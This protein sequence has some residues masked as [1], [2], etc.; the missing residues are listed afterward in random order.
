MPKNRRNPKDG[1]EPMK[2]RKPLGMMFLLFAFAGMA[3]A[4]DNSGRP[5]KIEALGR[6]AHFDGRSSMSLAKNDMILADASEA[7][8]M[9]WEKTDGLGEKDKNQHMIAVSIGGGKAAWAS[10]ASF[11][12]DPTGKILAWGRTRDDHDPAQEIRTLKPVVKNG[13]WHHIAAVFRYDANS[14]RLFLDG[15]PIPATK[16]APP[17]HQPRTANT[18]SDNVTVGSEDDASSAFFVG[19]LAHAEIWRRALS[20]QEIQAAAQKRPF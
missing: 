19:E 3:G 15:K 17:F 18:P 1:N 13:D 16:L 20:D 2:N 9:I 11:G 5:E 12:L 4:A 7:T 10:R 8:I 14:I 6:P